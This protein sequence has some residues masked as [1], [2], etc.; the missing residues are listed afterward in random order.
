VQTG[1]TTYGIRTVNQQLG[2]TIQGGVSGGQVPANPFVVAPAIVNPF[3]PF[4]A[5]RIAFGDINGDGTPDLIIGNGPNNPPLVTVINGTALLNINNISLSNPANI[6][7]QFYAYDPSYP[8]G[9]FV[10]AGDF[11][12]DGRAEI[13]TGTDVGGGPIVRVLQYVQAGDPG[14]VPGVTTIYTNVRDFSAP[15]AHIPA[16]FNAYDPNFRGG[17]RVAVG[18]VNG[19]GKPDIVTGAGPGGGPHVKVFSGA[20]GSVLRSF[21]AYSANFTGGVFV[22]AGDYNQDGKA[23]ILTGAGNG[24]APHVEVFSGAFVSPTLLA[25]FFAFPP[26]G[27]PGFIPNPNTTTGVGSVAF[28]DANGDGQ[29][30]IL[31]GTA[32]GPQARALVFRGP[33]FTPILDPGSE[34]LISPTLRDGANVAGSATAISGP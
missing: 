12:G 9:V 14:F 3:G 26:G 4:G 1:P 15:G 11:N 10:S 7:A 18:D 33:G 8:G 27:N 28:T 31:V 29:L 22:G 20:D 5:P 13:V 30:D 32:R 2:Q 24:G 16:M 21:F 23:D 17:V 6:L 25:S 19:D 34:L